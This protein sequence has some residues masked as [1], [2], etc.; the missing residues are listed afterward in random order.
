M[1]DFVTQF[2]MIKLLL[3]CLFLHTLIECSSLCDMWI[4]QVYLCSFFLDIFCQQSSL[5][6]SFLESVLNFS[7]GY[8]T[9]KYIAYDEIHLKKNKTIQRILLSIITL[10]HNKNSDVLIWHTNMG[11]SYPWLYSSLLLVKVN[12]IYRLFCTFYTCFG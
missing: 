12:P 10:Y 4:V 11:S 7:N 8:F 2:S 1:L 5:S 6:V 9:V 3:N